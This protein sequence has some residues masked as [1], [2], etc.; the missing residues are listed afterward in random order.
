MSLHQAIETKIR[1]ALAPVH[2][3]VEN[4][5]SKHRAPPGAESHFKVLV[6][7]A[8]FDGL[9]PVDRH[10]KINDLLAEDFAA[11]LHALSLRALTPAQ[12]EGER[13]K[14]QSPSCPSK[15]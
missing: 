7:S 8:A 12:W 14:F 13:T 1:E 6:V 4:E 3:E 15:G 9:G 2:L 11:G 10:R 5:S